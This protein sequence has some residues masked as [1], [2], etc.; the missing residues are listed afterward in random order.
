MPQQSYY[1]AKSLDKVLVF[2][3]E[4]LPVFVDLLATTRYEC[5]PALL[6]IRRRATISRPFRAVYFDEFNLSRVFP[7]CEA[8]FVD[9]CELRREKTRGWIMGRVD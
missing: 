1:L 5:L 3:I 7:K 6:R 8:V 2:I 9:E 4:L